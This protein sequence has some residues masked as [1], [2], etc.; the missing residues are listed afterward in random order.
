MYE[1]TYG[2]SGTA[3]ILLNAEA[4]GVAGIAVYKADGTLAGEVNAPKTS[5]RTGIGIAYNVTSADTAT[6]YIL[7]KGRSESEYRV[8]AYITIWVPFFLSCLL[9][10]TSR[11][12]RSGSARVFKG[13]I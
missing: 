10:K 9:T 5:R 2:A 13:R 8:T 12:N 7:R 4:F 3:T 1:I 6:V 11:R